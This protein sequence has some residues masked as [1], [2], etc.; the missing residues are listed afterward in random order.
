MS[1][2]TRVVA[3]VVCVSEGGLGWERGK[4]F[5]FSTMSEYLSMSQKTVHISLSLKLISRILFLMY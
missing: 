5:P 3:M 1:K 2:S 4:N